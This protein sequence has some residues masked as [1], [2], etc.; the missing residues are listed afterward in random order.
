MNNMPKDAHPR[1]IRKLCSFTGRRWGTVN[2][3]RVNRHIFRQ[4]ADSGKLCGVKRA[5]WGTGNIGNTV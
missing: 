4:L 5:I 2:R 3:F 1:M